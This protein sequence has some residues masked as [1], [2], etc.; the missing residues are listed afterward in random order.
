[1]GNSGFDSV[2]LARNGRRHEIGHGHL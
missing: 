2:N 1:M